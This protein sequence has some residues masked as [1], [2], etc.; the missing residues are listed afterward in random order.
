MNEKTNKGFQPRSTFCLGQQAF[1]NINE[2][3][4]ETLRIG[5]LARE[6]MRITYLVKYYQALKTTYLPLSPVI[7]KDDK[8]ALKAK[9][10]DLAKNYINPYNGTLRSNKRKHIIQ[11]LTEIEEMLYE[12]MQRISMYIKVEKPRS[13]RSKT[14]E[15]KDHIQGSGIPIPEQDGD[16]L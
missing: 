12:A 2:L 10:D 7:E 16:F 13:I 3:L 4:V 14:M 9:F 8:E 6:T 15:L 1:N 5:H 11:E